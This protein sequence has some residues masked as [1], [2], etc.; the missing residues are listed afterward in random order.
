MDFLTTCVTISLFKKCI[1]RGTTFDLVRNTYIGHCATCTKRLGMQKKKSKH[2]E[3][4]LFL[5]SHK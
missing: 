1:H 4:E 5:T 3:T 2:R